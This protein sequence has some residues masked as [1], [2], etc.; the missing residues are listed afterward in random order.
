[1]TSGLPRRR[2]ASDLGVGHSMLGEWISQYWPSDLSSAPSA[3]LAKENERLR[4]ENRILNEG[5]DILKGHAVLRDLVQCAVSDASC[6][7]VQID[8][9]NAKRNC[10]SPFLRPLDRLNMHTQRVNDDRAVHGKQNRENTFSYFVL[11]ESCKSSSSTAC[12]TDTV[13]NSCPR[14]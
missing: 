11:F 10:S 2:V 7:Q 8:C 4:L 6:R 5:R 9:M 12:C 13:E 14:T 3:N 1:M